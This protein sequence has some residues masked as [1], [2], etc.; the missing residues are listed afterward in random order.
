MSRV[1]LED[2]SVALDGQSILHIVGFE[3]APREIVTIFGP[4][5]SGNSTLL[6]AILRAVPVTR[7]R[8]TCKR[9][10]KVGFAP[11]KLTL[12]P[13]SPMPVR[14]FLCLAIRRSTASIAEASEQAGVAGLAGHQM[15][16]LPGGQFQ[17]VLLAPAL[18][19][20]PDLL[21]LDK[22]MQGLD[23]PGSAAFYLR[24]ETVRAEFG[25]AVP[26]VSHELHGAIAAS[27]RVI[28]LNGH[29]CCA[30]APAQVARAPEYCDCSARARG[31][32]LP[33]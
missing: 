22:A 33:A 19:E 20:G 13:K 9:G 11:Q 21:I 3:I 18:L 16:D 12:D 2:V 1:A 32:A 23:Q 26:M 25:F 28:Y 15:R 8:L 30:G 6:K 24:F 4:N 31:G 17:R 14:R 29:V 10:L 7:G 5:G 27:D